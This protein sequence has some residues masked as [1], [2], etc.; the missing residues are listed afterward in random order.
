[1][2]NLGYTEKYRRMKNK[3]ISDHPDFAHI[4]KDNRDELDNCFMSLILWF[5]THRTAPED[6]SIEEYSELSKKDQQVLIDCL[7]TPYVFR[8]HDQ[9]VNTNNLKF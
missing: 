3:L 5:Q 2:R 8:I 4:P 9:L 7:K 6:I 1:M